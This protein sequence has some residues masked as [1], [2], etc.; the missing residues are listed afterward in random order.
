M[1][2]YG[3]LVAGPALSLCDPSSLKEL[4]V[5][6]QNYQ[7]KVKNAELVQYIGIFNNQLTSGYIKKGVTPNYSCRQDGVIYDI[8]AYK[9]SLQNKNSPFNPLAKIYIFFPNV[10]SAM[11][12]IRFINPMRVKTLYV[13]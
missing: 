9:F 5:A 2:G 3:Q 11:F 7:N 12:M 6:H 1:S 4:K 10:R 8:E 13:L